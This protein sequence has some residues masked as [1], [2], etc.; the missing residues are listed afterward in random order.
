LWLT[1]T[2]KRVPYTALLGCFSDVFFLV[3]TSK[4][5]QTMFWLLVCQLAVYAGRLVLLL[6]VVV[7]ALVVLT[8]VDGVA[9]Q[10]FLVTRSVCDLQCIL[11]RP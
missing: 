5:V 3:A 6:V 2:E 11:D 1:D 4:V 9:A 10:G 7:V 8:D